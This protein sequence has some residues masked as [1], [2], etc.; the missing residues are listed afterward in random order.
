MAYAVLSDLSWG[1]NMA[2][3]SDA[4]KWLDAG[5]EEIDGKI[6]FVYATPVSLSA[7]VPAQ[8]PGY[9][10]LKRINSWLAMGRAILAAGTGNEDDQLHQLGAYYVREAT[11]ALDAIASGQI[12]LV[13]A[14]PVVEQTDKSTGPMIS[15]LD[16]VSL[17]ETFDSV[18]G[19]P[20]KTVLAMDRCIPS[21][22]PYTY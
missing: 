18:F 17:V 20:A 3:P 21:G 22:T 19:S 14:T 7:G 6:G 9:L 15:N 2:Q 8:R 11:A 10:L 13:G 5:A 1:S 16:E 4:Q 12:Q